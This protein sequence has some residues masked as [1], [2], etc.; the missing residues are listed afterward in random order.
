VIAGE[1]VLEKFLQVSAP[2]KQ[3]AKDLA[4]STAYQ[5]LRAQFPNVDLTNV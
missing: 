2:G 1:D 3:R 4:A 5:S